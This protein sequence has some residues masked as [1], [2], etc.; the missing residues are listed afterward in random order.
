MSIEKKNWNTFRVIRYV[1]VTTLANTESQTETD[2]SVPGLSIEW[3]QD[4]FVKSYVTHWSR[5]NHGI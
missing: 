1:G 3:L 2:P 5:Y 4:L